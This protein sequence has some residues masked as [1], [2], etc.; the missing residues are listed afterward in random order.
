MNTIMLFQPS[1]FD[2]VR[3]T[4]SGIL[5]FAR[6]AGFIVQTMKQT[7]NQPELT[8]TLDIWQPK[9]CI[10][11]CSAGNSLMYLSNFR[12]IPHICL[13]L[14]THY[15]DRNHHSLEHDANAIAKL[16]TTELIG[17]NCKSFG[18]V[19]SEHPFPW[20]VDRGICFESDLKHK[21]L[22]VDKFRGENLG[23][24]LMG[25]PK[26]CG[27]FAANDEV[28][29]NVIVAAQHAGLNVP[30]D[31]AVV[32]VDNDELYCEGTM[33]GITSIATDRYEVG[34]QLGKMLIEIINNQHMDIVHS[35]YKPSR[36]IRR[37]STR[38]LGHANQ[39]VNM[40]L[41]Y[42]RRQACIGPIR[43]EDVAKAMGCSYRL[44][45]QEFRTTL[46][47]SII[48]EVQNVRLAHICEQLRTSKRSITE[49]IFDC[50][51]ESESYVK[52][53]FARRFGMSMST[54]RDRETKGL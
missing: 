21:R 11:D 42:I 54:W 22:M 39:R 47:H 7:M 1:H 6:K 13:N 2:T 17:L 19:P 30:N 12:N 31:V 14:P 51:Y 15:H 41:E 38:R 26:P 49:I 4:R 9:G 18:Y 23:H 40:A 27:I 8:K 5:D 32:G 25:L 36:I 50:G 28:A 52:H 33:P 16:A 10:I 48:Q 46:G 44:A 20:S 34:I 29:Q 45:T 24:W 3:E 35:T 43:I 37:G 53:E